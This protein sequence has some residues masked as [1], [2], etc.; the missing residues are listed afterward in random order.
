MKRKVLGHLALLSL[1]GYVRCFNPYLFTLK[2]QPRSGEVVVDWKR[3]RCIDLVTLSIFRNGKEKSWE[4]QHHV[5]TRQHYTTVCMALELISIRLDFIIVFNTSDIHDNPARKGT[6]ELSFHQKSQ[7]LNCCPYYWSDTV[8]LCGSSWSMK[9]FPIILSRKAIE[10]TSC[11]AMLPTLAIFSGQLLF[12]ALQARYQDLSFLASACYL[13]L[14][15]VLHSWRV[16]C[17]G[18]LVLGKHVAPQMS[19]SLFHVSG[20]IIYQYSLL[21]SWTSTLLVSIVLRVLSAD[22]DVVISSINA[23]DFS[24]HKRVKDHQSGR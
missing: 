10:W 7:R 23:K 6:E 16:L 12:A 2:G 14:W 20:D 9:T 18:A 1:S 19:R 21:V 24:G 11:W 13:N 3:C 17:Y 15:D 4:Q 22:G 5:Q 8:E